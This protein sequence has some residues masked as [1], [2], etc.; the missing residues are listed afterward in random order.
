M[1]VEFTSKPPHDWDAYISRHEA[2]SAY[3]RSAAVAIGSAAFGLPVT[4][5]AAR[6]SE[7]QLVGVLPLV[8]QSSMLFG[9][10]LISVPFFNQGGILADDPEIAA[11]LAHGAVE[12]AAARRARHIELRHTEALASLRLPVRTDKVCMVLRLPKSEGALAEQLGSKLRSQIRRANREQPE[13]IWGG[14]ELIADF[15]RVFASTMHELGTPVYPRKFFEI[16]CSALEDVHWVLVLRIKGRA[17]AASILVRHGSRIEVPW[18]VATPAAKHSAI[19]MLLYWEMLRQSIRV[20]A[21]AFDFG[22]STRDSGTYRFKAQWGAQPVQLHWHYWLA[23]GGEIPRLNHTN[24]KY[25]IAATVWR[26]LPLWCVNVIGPHI[27]KKL[28]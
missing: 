10:F 26:R 27:V 4:F 25:A 22:R 9:R 6:G 24:P 1:Q 21:R 19:N 15:Y 28:P 23:A 17:E 20:G 12:L 7:H 2:A 18:A 8:E 13:V 3:H 11:S 16:T 14:R 5:L